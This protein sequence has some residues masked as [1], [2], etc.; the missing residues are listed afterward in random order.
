MPRLTRNQREQAIGRL[1]AGQRPWVI[2]NDL[3]C[4]IKTI[5]WLRERYN[6]AN[7]TNDRSCSGRPRVATAL[8]DLHLHRQHLQDRFRRA[9]ESARQIIGIHHRPNLCRDNSP[10]AE[11]FQSVLSTS[12]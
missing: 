8:Q 1:H 10:S 9:T 6:A 11:I 3:N 7:S 12:G 5:E 4:S 2:P